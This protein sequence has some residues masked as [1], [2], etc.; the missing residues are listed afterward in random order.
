MMRAMTCFRFSVS[1]LA[2]LVCGTALAPSA[3]AAQAI[4]SG[5]TI[6]LSLLPQGDSFQ[7][8]G[9]GKRLQRALRIRVDGAAI[10]D[11]EIWFQAELLSPEGKVVARHASPLMSVKPGTTIEGSYLFPGDAADRFPELIRPVHVQKKDGRV[12]RE[13][14]FGFG[15]GFTYLGDASENA[16]VEGQI[17]TARLVIYEK[18]DEGGA[19]VLTDRRVSLRVND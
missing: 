16:D 4:D 14:A 3:L 17:F 5:V 2:V 11:H 13:K 12:L 10:V 6:D 18:K 8:A 1:W 7:A 15:D 19:E 9:L